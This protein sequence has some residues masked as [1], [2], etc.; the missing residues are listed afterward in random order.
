MF[1]DARELFRSLR[2]GS[3][4]SSG[5]VLSFLLE[6]GPSLLWVEDSDVDFHL[7]W[8]EDHVRRCD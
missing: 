1:L 3:V 2:N 6:N 5:K 4:S 8:V 7:Q